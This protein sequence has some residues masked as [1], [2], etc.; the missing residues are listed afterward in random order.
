MGLAKGERLLS[1]TYERDG[2]VY[3]ASRAS[4][5][6]VARFHREGLIK[7]ADLDGTC[8]C[9]SADFCDT[10]AHRRV[11]CFDDGGGV[12]NWHTTNDVC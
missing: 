5:E 10:F 4:A 1:V 8:T 2:K 7:A 12:C 11:R 9:G 6:D 3:T